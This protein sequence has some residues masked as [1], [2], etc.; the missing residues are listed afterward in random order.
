MA[1][2]PLVKPD[3]KFVNQMQKIIRP[4]SSGYEL[5]QDIAP[6]IKRNLPSE[7]PENKKQ[8]L[9]INAPL[10]IPKGK[11]LV[12]NEKKKDYPGNNFNNYYPQQ[13]MNNMNN[14]PYMN[15]MNNMNNM[16]NMSS[17]N[18]NSY[19]NQY[20]Y[21]NNTYQ[22]QF[23]NQPGFYPPNFGSYVNNNMQNQYNNQYRNKHNMNTSDYNKNQ[24]SQKLL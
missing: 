22:K 4:I 11:H 14:I 13:Y 3:P 2:P 21:P 5:K 23:Q 6:E 24:N 16:S 9:N 1:E 19:Y 15:S 17:M 18:S 8:G 12:G 7:I 10:F 20:Y